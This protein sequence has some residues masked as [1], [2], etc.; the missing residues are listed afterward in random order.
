[1]K[2]NLKD[3]NG[4]KLGINTL[5][6][7]KQPTMS[8]EYLGFKFYTDGTIS[9][10]FICDKLIAFK[11]LATERILK[12]ES[13][14]KN[15]VEYDDSTYLWLIDN[16]S[17]IMITP[18]NPVFNFT[19]KILN[20][21]KTIISSIKFD[22][23]TINTDEFEVACNH[24]VRFR[25]ES[26]QTKHPV[27]QISF[28]NN[29]ISIWSEYEPHLNELLQILKKR[30]DESIEMTPIMSFITNKHKTIV[31]PID[32]KASDIVIDWTNKGM[33]CLND[34]PSNLTEMMYALLNYVNKYDIN[35][36][37]ILEPYLG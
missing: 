1:V 19:I 9:V 20:V 15:Y 13:N 30:I 26:K 25:I 14:G 7:A 31:V 33:I 27:Y 22:N 5:V 12:A 16:Q 17:H 6:K 3:L 24:I 36:Q 34:K 29:V 32:K 18:H 4:I 35:F 8:N 28:P 2:R 21:L 10:Q 23:M 11:A 37:L